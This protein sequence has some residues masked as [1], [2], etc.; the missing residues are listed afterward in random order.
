MD[1]SKKWWFKVLLGESSHFNDLQKIS[2][3]FPVDT[4]LQ[5]LSQDAEINVVLVPDLICAEVLLDW[6]QSLNEVRVY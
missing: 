2:F 5:K 4:A 3:Q 1:F 6:K